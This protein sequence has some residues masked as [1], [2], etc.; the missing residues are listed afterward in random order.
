[1]PASRLATVRDA[2]VAHMIDTLIQDRHWDENG[3]RVRPDMGS[4]AHVMIDDWRHEDGADFPFPERLQ[5]CHDEE[6]I[7]RSPEFIEM[8][9]HWAPARFD[10]AAGR[11][12]DAFGDNGTILLSRCMVVERAWLKEFLEDP[13]GSVG[14]Y[15]TYDDEAWELNAPW[16]KPDAMNDPV[17]V[18][19]QAEASIEEVDWYHTAL[20][21]M[22]Y[23]SGDE[24]Y[25]IRV[26]PD[27]RPRLLSMEY[28]D[29]LE[30]EPIE[31]KDR[32]TAPSI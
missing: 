28:L 20:A 11:L 22:D 12:V 18:V 9:R 32:A 4:G 27:A 29:E 19:F 31:F 8:L 3:L 15:W 13:S 25:E 1:M 21:A 10:Q 2:A 6:T 23:Y 30:G 7:A 26:L 5:D 16:G 24:E 17:E 14:L